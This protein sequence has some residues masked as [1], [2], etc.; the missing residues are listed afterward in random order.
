A[1][2]SQYLTYKS[3]V[4]V[5]TDALPN[6]GT[7]VD[8]VYHLINDWRS[9]VY[10]FY[11][12]PLPESGCNI[13]LLLTTPDGDFATATEQYSD[14]LN[15]IWVYNGPHIGNWMF[16][17]RQTAA[18]QSCNY[19]VYQSVYH[20]PGYDNQMDLFWS[21]S[22]NIDSDVG[23]PQ[24]L[25]G[26][27]H[28]IVMHLT[29]YPV[30]V[31]PERVQASLTISTIRNGKPTQIY[32]SNGIWRDLCTYNIYFPPFMCRIPNELLHFNFFAQDL[33]GFAVQRAGVMYCAEIPPPP[34][35]LTSCQNGGVMNAANTSCFCPPGFSGDLC[36][37][38]HFFTAKC[39]SKGLSPEFILSEVDMVFM[40]ELTAQAHAQLVS[41]NMQFAEM[42]RDVQAQSPTWINRFYLVGFNST[43]ADVM[44]VSSSRDPHQIIDEMNKLAN[45]IPTDTGCRVQL[46]YATLFMMVGGSAGTVYPLQPATTASVGQVIPL[47][48]RS[49]QVYG[50]YSYQCKQPMKRDRKLWDG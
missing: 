49:A 33:Q 3:P 4:Y 16:S 36:T 39:V 8:D 31:P 25:Y 32:A 38:I 46:D 21:T 18:T 22:L 7:Q 1:A 28:A 42:I 19:K 11:V 5:I 43:W 35:S 10:F 30:A 15:H 20:S 37:Q 9:P 41:L 48:Y 14:G 23:L 24:P 13:S 45:V 40:V 47:Q 29:N 17:F 6:D 50:Q 44:A 2:L 34:T 26:L 27:Q 12:E